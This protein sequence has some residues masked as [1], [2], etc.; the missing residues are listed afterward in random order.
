[1]LPAIFCALING[2]DLTSRLNHL[3]RAHN[4]LEERI[5]CSRANLYLFIPMKPYFMAVFMPL[6]PMLC[7]FYKAVIS[8]TLDK[9]CA[10]SSSRKR[11]TTMSFY[12]YQPSFVKFCCNFFAK[13]LG[14][15]TTENCKKCKLM[16]ELKS[17][18]NF[19]LMDANL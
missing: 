10:A 6:Q 16:E 7:R 15:N 18:V 14:H 3:G 12:M 5:C 13:T 8:G 19:S 9:K 17:R 4:T 1:M 11:I 2:C